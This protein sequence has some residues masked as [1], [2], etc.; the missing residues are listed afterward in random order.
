MG[1]VRKQ[2]LYYLVG[3]LIFIAASAVAWFGYI[4]PQRDGRL[5]TFNGPILSAESKAKIPDGFLRTLILGSAV[6]VVSGQ[7]DTASPHL[8]TGQ[9]EFTVTIK[10]SDVIGDL[11]DTYRNYFTHAG[12]T[13][14][15]SHQ[16]AQRSYLSVT[17]GAY[18]VIVVLTSDGGGTRAD[19]RQVGPALVKH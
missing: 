7:Q 12:W 15:S 17:R 6:T 13:I 19:I 3:S 8:T 14:T 10:T 9:I 16:T 1:T 11:F 18:N 2:T 4:K 5:Y